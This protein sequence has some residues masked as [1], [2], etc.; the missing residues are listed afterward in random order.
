VLDTQVNGEPAVWID[1]DYVLVTRN[2]EYSMSRLISQGHTLVWSS[3]GMTFRLETD[4]DLEAA[5]RT[6]ESIR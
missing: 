1:A 3:G 4:V 2:G 6:A 5:I